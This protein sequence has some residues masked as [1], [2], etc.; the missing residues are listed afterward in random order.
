M[1]PLPLINEAYS[2]IVS[3]EYKKSVAQNISAT[4]LL[5][6]THGMIDEAIL[7][8][9]PAHQKWK[10]NNS[11]NYNPYAT[12]GHYKPRG[13]LMRDCYRLAQYSPDHPRHGE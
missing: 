12:C 11:S 5:G 1:N 13:H 9:R 7:Y 10:R 4:W 3:D 8:T 2:M 6:M